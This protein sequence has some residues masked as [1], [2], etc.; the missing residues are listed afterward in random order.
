LAI[1]ATI[2][3]FRV[4]V[5]A[6]LA[7]VED[8]V[9]THRSRTCLDTIAAHTRRRGANIAW[10]HTQAV[11]LAPVAIGLVAVV[12]GFRA[13]DEL[14]TTHD[15][16]TLAF[17]AVEPWLDFA[18]RVAAITGSRAT[19]VALLPTDHDAVPTKLRENRGARL[20]HDE[21]FVAVLDFADVTAS[22]VGLRRRRAVLALLSLPNQAVAANDDVDLHTLGRIAG[23]TVLDGTV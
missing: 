19:V 20:A 12:T 2:R 17:H 15:R 3:W 5:I 16:A 18:A 14:V 1:A 13:N 7:E 6:L 21:A 9:G 22:V 10:S 4:A 23:P 8:P 11:P